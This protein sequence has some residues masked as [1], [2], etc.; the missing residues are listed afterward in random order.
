MKLVTITNFGKNRA[1]TP[2][3]VHA[4]RSEGELLEILRQCRGRRIRT[5]GRLHSWSEVLICDDVLLDLCH[6]NDVQVENRHGKTWVT[7][8]G[9]CQI[10]RLLAELERQS[11]GML[12]AIGLITAQTIAGAISTG[13]HGSG[14]HAISQYVEELRIATYDAVTGEP[15]IRTINCRNELRAA[16]CSLGAL[17]VIVS[18]SFWSRPQYFVEEHFRRYAALEDVVAAEQNYPLQQFF[19][20]PW[21]WQYY[22]QHR[23]ETTQRRLGFVRLYNWYTFLVFDILLHL[24]VLFIVR[25]LRSSNAVQFFFRNIVSHTVIQNWAV[26]GRPQQLLVMKH[27]LFRHIECE[28]FVK[29][30]RLV[31][32]VRYVIGLLKHFDGDPA[33]IDRKFRD[34]LSASSILHELDERCGSYTHHYPICIRRVLHDDTFLSMAN[35][36]LED[37]YAISFISYERPSQRESFLA[38]AEI[39]TKTMAKLFDGRPHWGKICPLTSAEVRRLYPECPR[40]RAIAGR[41]DPVGVFQ[42]EWL[43]RTLFDTCVDGDVAVPRSK[44]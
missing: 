41:F 9:G 4:P 26:V 18:V 42:N 19:L 12:P 35:D 20:L 10:K 36:T 15:V 32:A 13:T 39:L 21:L 37:S 1:F 7:V 34:E 11:A 3:R 23:R 43:R 14:N 33:A 16:R 31:E 29:R 30:S 38:F 2:N 44:P 24:F 40:F 17:G 22:V 27:E 25:V 8:G 5:I 28:I 6:M